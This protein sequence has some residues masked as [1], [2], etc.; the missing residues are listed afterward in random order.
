MADQQ[1]SF[2]NPRGKLIHSGQKL[3]AYNTYLKFVT[4]H[5]SKTAAVKQTA[6]DTGIG[7]NTIWNLIKEIEGSG[8]A[9]SPKKV[10]KFLT[11]YDKLEDFEKMA[12]RRHVHTFY[13]RNESPTIAKVLNVVNND[14]SLPNFSHSSFIRVLRKLG[15]KYDKRTRKSILIEKS[16]IVLWRRK[17]LTA[18]RKYRDEGRK[19]YYT[20]ETWVNAGHVKSKIWHDTTIKTARQATIE[21]LSTG[22]KDPTGKGKRLIIVHI[23]S[24]TGFVN[25]GLLNFESKKT[26]KL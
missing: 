15:F 26:G 25:G 14:D 24:D 23:G 17:Y 2:K 18:I 16:E 5:V 9:R 7:Q 22:V 21:G 12:I 3:M 8:S 20:D 10:R 19:I 6:I 11:I 13:F 1:H 4:N